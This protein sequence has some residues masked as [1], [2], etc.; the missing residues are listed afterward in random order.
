MRYTK[1][2]LEKSDSVSHRMSAYT[3]R[4]FSNSLI[5]GLIIACVQFIYQ[6]FSGNRF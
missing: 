6:F 4:T 3:V 2:G 1:D 5:D